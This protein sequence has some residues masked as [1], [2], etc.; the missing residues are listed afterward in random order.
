M[1][2]C[3][4]AP[5]TEH[6]YGTAEA[7]ADPKDDIY[8]PPSNYSTYSQEVK[9]IFEP[10]CSTSH[11]DYSYI[12][13]RQEIGKSSQVK[14]SV[15]SHVMTASNFSVRTIECR[16]QT[17]SF[18][19]HPHYHT[20][21]EGSN[22]NTWSPSMASNSS[23]VRNY[24]SI[25]HA[26]KNRKDDE[27]SGPP[28]LAPVSGILT[29]APGKGLIRPI[30]FKPVIS[31]RHVTPAKSHTHPDRRFSSLDDGYG[32]QDYNGIGQ[33]SANTSHGSLPGDSSDPSSS[34]SGD[35]KF[36]KSESLPT[37]SLSHLSSSHLENFIQT[38][39]PSDSGVG[40]L[41]A[42]LKEK[43]HEIMALREVMD[44]N[45]RAIFQV[46]E[47]QKNS[48]QQE[49]K[50]AKEEYEKR[51]ALHQKKILKSEQMLSMQV[52]KL[53][54]S[55]KSLQEDYNQ[56]CKAKE[57]LAQRCAKLDEQIEIQKSQ[58]ERSKCEMQQKNLEC[59]QMT[60]RL[61]ENANMLNKKC[62][63]V[64]LLKQK[65]ANTPESLEGTGK[66]SS[67]SPSQSPDC[68][69]AQNLNSSFCLLC[70]VACQTDDYLQ[71]L[72]GSCA[73]NLADT[74]AL[75]L[76]KDKQ[77]LK[78]QEDVEHY[79]RQVGNYRA[80]FESER[81]QWLEEK[82]K[83]IRYQKQLQLNYVQMFRKN[84][85]LEAE[86]EQLTLELENRDLKLLALNGGEESVC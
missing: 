70:D 33:S 63:E 1:A 71:V 16:S 78:L 44:K 8:T 10:I 46:Y 76:E 84:K 12:P 51:V 81:D 52:F 25:D 23:G 65:V 72:N 27:E 30:A 19:A 17:A 66:G 50:E 15:S 83:V 14:G 3:N 22:R 74:A 80:D 29:R 47:E 55:N 67:R 2:S 53:Q 20:L 61:N 75:L 57:S 11:Q 24:Y 18:R 5:C 36:D 9:Y 6:L 26:E 45:E 4:D 31:S 59:S 54:Q 73:E 39:S 60:L 86:V 64:K 82:G 49:L 35:L 32:S 69:L 38:P 7:P 62:E 56:L 42:M 34:F 37:S 58:L 77:I 68:L 85:N 79:K 43:E 21:E 41:E 48:W 40:E 13:I 28:K